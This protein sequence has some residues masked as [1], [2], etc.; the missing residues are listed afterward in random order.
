MSDEK[1]EEPSEKK[2]KKAR[3]EG[4][5]AKSTDLVEVASLGAVV[6]VLVVGQHYLVDSMRTIVNSAIDFTHGDRSL[7]DLW[8]ALADMG[9]RAIGLLCGVTVIALV[10][11][12]F[13]LA[14]QVGLQISIQS[15]APKLDAVM[16]S[17]GIK[18]IFSMNSVIDLAKMTLKAAVLV[19]VMWQT[20]KQSMP[21]VA[22]SLDQSVPQLISV[23]WSVLMHVFMVALVV[24]IVIGACDY[25][26][27]HWLFMRKNRMSKDEV[28]RERKDS[29]GNPEMKNERK[30]IA[31]ELSQEAPKRD[32]G[33]AN[34]V[35]VNPVHYA[36]A[37]RYDPTEFP[38]PVVL[39]KG[40][41]D[42]AVLL[43]RYATQLGVPIVANPP[44][45]RM[46]HKVPERQAV[47][48]ELF[49]VVAAILRWVD[50]LAIQPAKAE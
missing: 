37:L 5:V 3:E 45:A 17:S 24:F 7:D 42:E 33:R 22:S 15:V 28:K 8:V 41:D 12:I 31:K 14:P 20:I 29:E 44:V 50:G 34:V 2:L 27:Q 47:P 4:Q 46:L 30:R 16:P 19:V 48:E 6:L 35:V 1:T 49:E 40:V 39:S 23:L 9:L 10:A 43:R 32:I 11:A 13:A 25:K 38:L 26:L 36:V 18:K 21:V